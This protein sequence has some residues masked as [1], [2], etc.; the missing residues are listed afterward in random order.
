VEVTGVD[1]WLDI[2]HA[3][4]TFEGRV[5]LAL[6]G[7]ADPLVLDSSQLTIESSDL[8]G[9]AVTPVEDTPAGT[10]RFPSV[11]PGS[12]TLEIRYR[13]AAREGSLVGMYV[14]PAGSSYVLTTM[15]FPTG[16]ARLLPGFEHPA[17][18]TVYRLT[19]RVDPGLRAVF[20]TAPEREREVDGRREI[21]FAPTPRMSAYLL[22]LGVGPFETLTVPGGRWSVIVDASPGRAEAGRYCAERASEIL[23]GYEEYYRLPYPLSKLDLIALEDFWAG[24][25]ENW[26][27]ISARE[28]V[29]LVD[30]ATSVSLRRRILVTLAHE[31]GH[32]WF[33]DLVTNAWWDDF[34]LNEAFAT[35][36]AYHLVDR[37]YPS[38]ESWKE[39]LS[40]WIGPA[41]D[42]D[43]LPST[44]PVRV[45]VASP[46][47]VGENSDHITY[48]KGAA[49]LRMIEAFLGEET[50]RRGVTRYLTEHQYGNATSQ[51][52][53][54]A[55][56]SESD[57]PVER[58]MTEWITRPG[59]PVLRASLASGQLRVR[60]E[61]FRGDGAPAPGVWPIP[62]RLRDASGERSLLVETAEVTVPLASPRGLR[63]DPGRNA[64][65]RIEYEGTLFEA[66]FAEFPSMEPIDQWGF[67]S[68]LGALVYAGRASL[69]QVV[70]LVRTGIHLTDDLAILG[71]T[72]LVGDLGF[73]LHDVPSFLDPAREFLRVQLG[74]IGEERRADEPESHR[75]LRETLLVAR[76]ELDREF[77]ASLGA[78]FADFD[79]LPAELRRPVSIA[80]AR[81]G[82]A[83]AVDGLVARLRVP[84]TSGEH[85]VIHRALGALEDPDALRRTFHLI[86]GPEIP[87]SGAFLLL[88]AMSRNPVGRGML[89]DWYREN[90]QALGD[91]WA[92][93]PLQSEFLRAS[94]PGMGLDREA[95]IRAYF[96]AHTPADAQYGV[97]QGLD[98]LR[99]S[100][101]LREE[102]RRGP[103]NGSA[104]AG[105]SPRG[106]GTPGSS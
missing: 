59:Y 14:S 33:G 99:L 51:D 27:A 50:F 90:A 67:I 60:Q 106:G 72:D 82:G 1:W 94:L 88:G 100:S 29:L 36:V 73:V 25:M 91:L 5:R 58:I 19:L 95:E 74:R 46:A 6:E 55:L 103:G 101:R 47:Q 56:A 3:E 81:S 26:G 76:A 17:V 40:R 70:A 83:R 23:T 71:L 44:H 96:A 38:E 2:H 54:R 8:D 42:L 7:A 105:L 45:P 78:R 32:Q 35:F 61:R 84:G 30:A 37:L 63:I 77:A 39:M 10:I 15:L 79:Q 24:A 66:M 43:A 31:I 98:S 97:Q 34:W 4:K 68:D 87:S 80:F 20:N 69:D 65:V 11:G 64:F 92:G 57:R 89:F 86:P 12:H 102:F 13:G 16:S 22:Y 75:I 52:L 62:L 48:G 49:V 9:R 28:S 21:V 53:W 18:K 41:L 93:T 104:H 85:A